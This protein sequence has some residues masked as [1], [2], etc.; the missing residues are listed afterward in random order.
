MQG[1]HSIAAVLHGRLEKDQP[2]ARGKTRTFAERTPGGAAPEIAE[3]YQA[4]DARQ[5]ELGR[6]LAERPGEWAVRAW[7]DPQAK[8]GA[9]RADWERVAGIVE[10][11]REAAGITDPKVAI[12]PVPAGK[13]V[14]REMFHASIRAL[15]LPDDRALMAAMGNEDLEARL[16]ERE[17][18]V[19]VAPPEVSAELASVERQRNVAATQARQAAEASDAH[20]AKSAEALVH[21]HDGQLSGLRV[22][23]AAHREWAEAHA[24]L[25]TAAMAA[26]RELRERGLAERIPVTDSEVA[27][28]SAKPRPFPAIDPAEAARWKAEQTAQVQADREARAEASARLAPVT[29]A[30]IEKYGA[31]QPE[32]EV[33]PERAAGE[34]NIAEIRAELERFGELIDQIPDREAE[35]QAQ[36]DEIAA[37]PGIRPEPE[38]EPSLEPSWQPAEAGGHSDAEADVEA[39]LEI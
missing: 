37:E 9:E 17:R 32:P 12:G 19:A 23:D 39:E 31:A 4:A 5:A 15:R 35:R 34:A 26:E 14:L 36:R 10:S 3:G 24:G 6:Q 2:P 21:V 25:E 13:G 27:E 33:N 18:A 1:A 8:T 28:A 11:Y 22:A 7:G 16:A 20:M 38:A 29:D 30:E